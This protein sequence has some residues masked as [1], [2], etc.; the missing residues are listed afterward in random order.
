MKDR[1]CR[2]RIDF[3]P[4]KT[5]GRSAPSCSAAKIKALGFFLF[6][7]RRFWLLEVAEGSTARA[8]SLSYIHTSC[9]IIN[10]ARI[11]LATKPLTATFTTA[12][13]ENRS[14]RAAGRLVGPLVA[15]VE[16]AV[17]VIKL[18]CRIASL[19]WTV[20]LSTCVASVHPWSSAASKA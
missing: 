2:R 12:A 7:G 13:R 9:A 8:L 1:R 20:P 3:P 14:V 11:L 15:Q 5:P 4:F 10:C 16:C 6:A 17:Y 18:S 19:Y